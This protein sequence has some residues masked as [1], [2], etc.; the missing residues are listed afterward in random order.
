MTITFLGTNNWFDTP[1]GSTPST[2]IET[3]ENY[4]ILDAGFGIHR[5]K[6]YIKKN[7]PVYIFLSHM[8]IDHICGLH[9]M[10][11]FFPKQTTTL[12]CRK[13]DKKNLYIMIAPPF[14]SKLG[15]DIK[16][17]KLIEITS[18]IRRPFNFTTLK[19]NHTIPTLGYR[20]EIDNKIITYCVDTA[21]SENS[22]KL[23]QNSDI[24]IHECAL[25]PKRIDK[26]WGHSSPE[27]AS[28]IAKL[29][30]TKKLILTAFAP[31]DYPTKSS[32]LKAQQAGRKI[33]KNTFSAFD[34]MKI[35]I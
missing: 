12:F 30:K 11:G 23:A 8:H 18:K 33:F 35:K 5:A 32:R 1:I 2:L 6:K 26:K 10:S 17:F 19:L 22:I 7:K 16:N 21:F 31:T 29:S 13:G 34:E 28:K 20:F 9:G 27:T 14:S 24:L 3:K 25:S 15:T 4:I